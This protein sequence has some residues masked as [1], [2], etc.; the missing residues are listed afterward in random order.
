M[1]N[2]PQQTKSQTT[3]Q[4]LE[5][6][7]WDSANA[8][9]GPVDPADFKN[10]VFPML[11]WK[12]IS[13]TW[14][15]EHRLAVAEF[16]D[17]LNDEIEAD[18]HRFVMSAGTRWRDITTKV[19]NVGHLI[20]MTFSNIEQANPKSLAGIFG[21]VSWANTERLPDTALH[22]LIRAMNRLTLDPEHVSH[23]LLGQGYEYLL[24]NFADDS[25]KKAG[26]FFTPR[27][28]VN[29]I[30]D[31]LE[32]QEGESVCDPA[33]GSGGMLVATIN[34]MKARGLDARTLNL[35]AQE[36]NLTTAGIARMN[37]FLHEIESAHVH[38]GDTLRDPGFRTKSGALQ[39]FDVVIANPPFSLKNW[40]A[41][42]W[43]ADSRALCGV[44]P[45]GNGDYAWV[46]HMVASSKPGTGRVGVVMPHGV[47]FRG[48]KEAAIRECLIRK[49]L[50][51]AVIGLPPNL[52]YSTSIP[53]CILV[54]R[55]AK[56]TGRKDHVLFVDG[57]ARFAKGKNQNRMSSDDVDTLVKAYRTGMD[58]DGDGGANVRL[59]PLAEIEEN[60]F[61]LNV[62][63][64]IKVA[65]AEQ[66]N[67]AD[68]IA[69]YQE[70]RDARI[71]A[72]T[73]LFARLTAAG[74]AQLGD[75][76]V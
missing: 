59:V 74:I 15:H 25:G 54:F 41:D 56:P 26:E 66:L 3:L 61:D 22:G 69:A 52:F 35:Y 4:D 13:D 31:I 29:L 73:A 7:L 1:T 58:P 2:T 33:A 71:E 63:R 72:E 49:D 16:G 46:E 8:L 45:D 67:V 19:N 6:R 10:Y 44:P 34:R 36:V 27:E 57:S 60:Q 47:L 18:Y 28:V 64:Y 50:L 76:D 24:K 14:E 30:V 65:A 17:E 39:R 23:D 48:G 43:V 38:R 5:S 12:W 55:T 40:G 9:R 37:L 11:F 62:G 32:P 21:D 51:E 75:A 20:Q 68:A 42:G 53:A 70:A